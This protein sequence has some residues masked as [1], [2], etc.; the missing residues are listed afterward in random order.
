MHYKIA[1][2]D[3]SAA[4]Q[5]YIHNLIKC[6]AAKMRHTV[7]VSVFTS[8]ESFLFHYANQKDYD[9]L[10]LDIEL[11]DM[12]GVALAKKLR[13][14]H[15]TAQIVFITGYPEFIA[16]GYEVSALHYL[17][18]PVKEETLTKVLERAAANLGKAAKTVVFTVSKETVRVAVSDILYIEAFAHSCRVNMLEESLE[19][20]QGIS[21]LEKMLGEGFIRTHRSYLVGIAYIKRISKSEV[22]LDNGEKV[23]LSRGNYQAV[24]QSFIKYYMG[25]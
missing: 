24:N 4:D 11:G 21:E 13:Q 9:I 6:W 10:L 8:A 22:T 18:K 7:Q 23:P 5:N 3:D 1:I 17:L 25:E 14:D 20:R 2:C 12:D 15:E 16:E 19:I